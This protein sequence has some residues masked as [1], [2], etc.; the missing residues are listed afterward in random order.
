[1]TPAPVFRST[2]Q[3]QEINKWTNWEDSEKP[4]RYA[5][6]PGLGS[7]D[8]LHRPYELAGSF[9]QTTIFQEKCRL[10]TFC[11]QNGRPESSTMERLPPFTVLG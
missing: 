1:M 5:L 6:I 10:Q 2:K 9:F 11:K 3:S 7:F 8:P 4:R